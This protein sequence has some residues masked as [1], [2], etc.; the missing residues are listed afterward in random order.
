MGL[1]GNEDNNSEICCVCPSKKPR[2]AATGL[3]LDLLYLFYLFSFE[4]RNKINIFFTINE[5]NKLDKINTNEH[6]IENK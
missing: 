1:L 2:P 5:V 3:F 4:A 6:N